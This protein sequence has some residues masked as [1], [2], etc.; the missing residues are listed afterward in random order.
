LL[1]FRQPLPERGWTFSLIDFPSIAACGMAVFAVVL[2]TVILFWL[3]Y[4]SWI[5]GFTAGFLLGCASA[6]AFSFVVFCARDFD[7]DSEKYKREM[8]QVSK[9]EGRREVS[10]KE[11]R[12]ELELRLQVKRR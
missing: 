6:F 3:W 8:K 12:E 1:I 4:M 7:R 2:A 11:A 9:A 5:R 10:F